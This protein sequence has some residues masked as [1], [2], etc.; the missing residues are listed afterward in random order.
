MDPKQELYRLVFRFLALL[1]EMDDCASQLRN[2]AKDDDYGTKTL[3]D[4]DRT[5]K[6]LHAEQTTLANDIDEE[7]DHG[8]R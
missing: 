4:A 3:S 1:N 2:M 7:L 5:I 6:R 8:I